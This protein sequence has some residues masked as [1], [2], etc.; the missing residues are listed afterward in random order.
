MRPPQL[1]HRL[2]IIQLNVQVLVYALE[3]AADLDFVLQFDG[4]FV[5][6]ERLEEA[7]ANMLAIRLLILIPASLALRTNLK[8]SILTVIGMGMVVR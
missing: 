5:L 2:G 1:I 3:G 6:D 8:N 4:D 7:G